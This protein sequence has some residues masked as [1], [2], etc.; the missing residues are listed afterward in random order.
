MVV[1][2]MFGC[3]FTRIAGMHEKDAPR[4][5]IVGYVSGTAEVSSNDAEKLTHINY[6]FA[7]IDEDGNLFFP[8]PDASAHIKKLLAL[9]NRDSY[10]RVLVSV[11][12]WGADYFSDVALT[13]SSRA[14][15]AD[16]VGELVRNY[17]LDGV[18]IDWE[19][20]GQP[21]PGIAYREEDKVNFTLLIKAIRDRLDE[22]EERKGRRFPGYV[23]TVASSDSETYLENTEM[24]TLHHYVDYINVMSYD[25][26]TAGSETTGHHAGLN[27]SN[28]SIN[29]ARNTRA[30]IERYLSLG[31]PAE[32]I[33]MGVAFYG[34]S[35][36]GV[37]SEN[38]GL[39]QKYDSFKGAYGYGHIRDSFLGKEGY[40]RFWDEEA[41]APYLWNQ[42]SSIFISYEDPV[43]LSYKGSYVR[44]NELGGIMYW[45]HRHDKDGDLLETLYGVLQKNESWI[46]ENQPSIE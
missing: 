22:M 35:W 13:E 40:E 8:N 37:R 11:G 4:Y 16:E 12:G 43:S 26:Y 10:L 25:F 41:K 29:K 2:V 32:K 45:E 18:D 39:Y 20:P 21:G 24:D 33:V 17:S 9:K 30:G 1:L 14:E 5:R 38:N 6:A 34:R 27:K 3:Q 42:D 44:E 28:A 31:V 15:F 19:Y 23:L 7:R 36:S 46:L